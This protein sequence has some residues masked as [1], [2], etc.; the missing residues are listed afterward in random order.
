LAEPSIYLAPDH[1]SLFMVSIQ[2][3]KK[4]YLNQ[5]E[6]SFQDDLCATKVFHFLHMV[7]VVGYD[8]IAPA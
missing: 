8:D 1:L 4:K 3:N 7:G 6:L 2:L 5:A